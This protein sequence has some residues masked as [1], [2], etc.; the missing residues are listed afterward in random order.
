[1]KTG[2][3]FTEDLRAFKNQNNESCLLKADILYLAKQ[4]GL[5]D[6]MALNLAKNVA[7]IY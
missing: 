1:M 7:Q 5:S 4:Y 2:K 6:A 3:G